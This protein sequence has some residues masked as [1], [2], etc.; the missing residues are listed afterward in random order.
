MVRSELPNDEFPV[1]YCE[2]SKKLP[3]DTVKRVQVNDGNTEETREGEITK[4]LLID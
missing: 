2:L 1:F 4:C 3:E